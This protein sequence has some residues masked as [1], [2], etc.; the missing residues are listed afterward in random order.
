MFDK[1]NPVDQSN[2][3][4]PSPASDKRRAEQSLASSGSKHNLGDAGDA[5][6]VPPQGEV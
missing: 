3:V 5:E 1:K 6:E 2:A 4:G